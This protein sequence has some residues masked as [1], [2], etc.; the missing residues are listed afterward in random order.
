M[1]AARRAIETLL[2]E[3]LEIK[4]LILPDGKDPDDFIRANGT[5][6]YNLLRGKAFPY[7]QFVL[8]PPYR[9][10]ILMCQ[11]KG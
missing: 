11:A 6:S 4:V 2:A 5:D 7:L 3:D 10:A 9:N 8:D 1:K